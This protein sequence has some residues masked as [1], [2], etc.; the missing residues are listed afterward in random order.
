MKRWY[1]LFELFLARI[2]EFFREPEVIFWVY[3]FPVLLAVGLG[4]AFWGREPEPPPVDIEEVPELATLSSSLLEQ[5]RADH[6]PA[7][8]HSAGDCRQRYRIGRTALYITPRP[9]GFV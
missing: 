6:L 9:D 1:P 5:L 3:G 4:I 8:I 2:R 7:E